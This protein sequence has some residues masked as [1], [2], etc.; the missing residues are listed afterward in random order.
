MRKSF[1]SAIAI[2]ALAFA[3]CTEKQVN[4]VEPSAGTV[5]VN[6]VSGNELSN[7][8]TKTYIDANNNVFW[9]P[10]GEYLKVLETIDGTLQEPVDSKEGVTTDGT[11]ALFAVNL[12]ENTTG[13]SYVYNVFYPASAY[14]TSSNTNVARF[15]LETPAI[16]NPTLNSFDPS[17]D[18]LI[19][20]PVTM[21]AQPAAETNLDLYF[22]RII[23][24][25]KMTISGLASTDPVVSVKFVAPS[26]VALTGRSYVNLTEGSIEE[27]GYYNNANSSVE[28]KYSSE[29]GFTNDDCAIFTCF[30]ATI[31]E[32][33]EFTVI[34]ETAVQKFTKKVTIPTGKSL[35]FKVGRS[36]KFSVN[37]ADAAVE[38]KETLDGTYAILLDKG[39]YY[40]AV[41]SEN[42]GNNQLKAV[43]YE[44]NGTDKTI[45]DSEITSNLIW[46]I[47]QVGDNYSIKTSDNKY[48]SWPGSN[49]NKATTTDELYELSISKNQDGTYCINSVE[50]AA[51]KLQQSGTNSYFAF[52]SSKQNGNLNL[53]K[54]A[55]DTRAKLNAP[56]DVTATAVTHNSITLS[57]TGDERAEN[58][59]ISYNDTDVIS[60][61][62]TYTIEGLTAAAEYK[63]SIVAKA[64]DYKTSDACEYTV[65]TAAAP[66][67]YVEPYTVVSKIADIEDGDYYLA[68]NTYMLYNGKVSK[69]HLQTSSTAAA[70]TGTTATSI[71]DDAVVVTLT[72]DGAGKYT[73]KDANDKYITVT[74]AGSGGFA[75]SAT[76]DTKWTF[77]DGDTSLNAVGDNYNA[78]IRAYDGTTFRSYGATSSNGNEIYLI[79]INE[80]N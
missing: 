20:K 33:M 19:A 31:S 47:E 80:V 34:V 70:V 77:S 2:I 42:T 44:Y 15:K 60:E 26:D 76:A 46:T 53:V 23:A 52:Y 72:S 27:Y 50:D 11:T 57:W 69:G 63:F 8:A 51:R 16:Q 28:M 22:A 78:R 65:S 59:V 61:S 3:A 49:S 40:Y 10:S 1:F 14:V 24:V 5:T 64:A 32:G 75:L 29:T 6:F 13:T 21:S 43:E 39:T 56:A 9:S 48:I 30:P 36:T 37:M 73:L 79:K 58:Y 74:K 25:G 38:V 66:E 17:A 45:Y 18:L 4:P 12:P 67:G 7:D 71:P 35:D 62:T 41:S 55:A 68:T 54:V